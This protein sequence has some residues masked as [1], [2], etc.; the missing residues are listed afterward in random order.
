MGDVPAFTGFVALMR[1]LLDRQC[2]CEV[3]LQADPATVPPRIMSAAPRGNREGG[4]RL[5]QTAWL[6]RPDGSSAAS[7][8]AGYLVRA[9]DTVRAA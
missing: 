1:M 9:F 2:D 6:S 3:Q 4:L 8:K 7:Y 5:G